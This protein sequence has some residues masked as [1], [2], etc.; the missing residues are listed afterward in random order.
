MSQMMSSEDFKLYLSH[1]TEYFAT[2]DCYI[3]KEIIRSK[4]KKH[5]WEGERE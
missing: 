5:E 3:N 2:F 1:Y 4:K